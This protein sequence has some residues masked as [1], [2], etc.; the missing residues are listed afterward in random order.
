MIDIEKKF[1][2][3]LRPYLGLSQLGHE[4]ERFLWYS[5]RWCFK[6]ILTE[7]RKRVM[8]RGQDE[9][10]R[11]VNNL[12]KEHITVYADQ[13]EISLFD[14]HVKGHIDGI[15]IDV[16]NGYQ[17][18]LLEMK[19]LAEKYF[20]KYEQSGVQATNIQYYAQMQTYMHQ[21]RLSKTL[22]IVVNKN[23]DNEYREFVDL[24]AKYANSMI[25]KACYI[26][27][28]EKSPDRRPEFSKTHFKCK[29]WCNA[30]DICHNGVQVENNC[31]T[32]KNSMLHDYGNW[33]CRVYDLVIVSEQQRIACHN[34]ELMDC[35]K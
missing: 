32:C 8:Q 21:L 23:D 24:D 7:R 25:D 17:S 9:E 15:C 5:F 6:N 13:L 30:F 34:F 12:K 28:S 35:L 26:I 31:R 29:Y 27:S 33:L 3:P 19:L 14:D 20:K 22:F 16:L 18:Y 10:D 4:C 1:E 2:E 11:I